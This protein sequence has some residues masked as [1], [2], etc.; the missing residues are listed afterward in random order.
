MYHKSSAATVAEAYLE[1]LASRGLKYFFG[2]SGTDFAPIIEAFAKRDAE[3]NHSLIP[4]TV[5]HE[6][7]AVAMA[8][9]YTMI[10]GKPQAVMVHVIVGTANALGGIINASRARLPM[11]FTAGRTPLTEQGP[12]GTRDLGIHWAQESFDQA[13]M[14]REFVNDLYLFELRRLKLELVAREKDE[15]RRLRSQYSEFVTALRQH[16]SVLS[17]PADHWLEP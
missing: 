1:L 5:P 10:T 7:T 17:S 14:V 4:I 11:F 16:Y 3:G 15:G 13:A 12:V 2:N 8:H 6:I 9:G